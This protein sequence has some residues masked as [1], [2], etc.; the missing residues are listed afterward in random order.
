MH[1]RR[2]NDGDFAQKS[3]GD[4]YTNGES[5]TNRITD[6][7]RIVSSITI[8]PCVDRPTLTQIVTRQK[9]HQNHTNHYHFSRGRDGD[10]PLTH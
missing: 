8:Y 9:C 2:M 6:S 4:H 5:D 7:K 1:F 10:V 3:P